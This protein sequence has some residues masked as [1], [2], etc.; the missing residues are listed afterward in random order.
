MNVWDS[1]K[2]ECEA[3]KRSR[4]RGEISVWRVTFRPRSSLHL[5]SLAR[6]LSAHYTE[7]PL[8][9]AAQNTIAL[10]STA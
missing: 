1:A 3:E 7:A 5:R 6:C 10:L 4:V 8:H 2:A 9:A